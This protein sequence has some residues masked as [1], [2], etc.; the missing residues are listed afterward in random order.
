MEHELND[1]QKKMLDWL[2]RRGAAAPSQVS[3]E[4]QLPPKD[5]WDMIDQLDKLGLVVVRNDP[6]SI[7]GVLVFA[8]PMMKNQFK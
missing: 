5:T 6:H 1:L 7:D 2:V 8:A 4:M 3:A